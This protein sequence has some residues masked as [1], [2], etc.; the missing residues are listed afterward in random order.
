ME[1]IINFINDK[2]DRN[3]ADKK[4]VLYFKGENGPKIFD[5]ENDDL[6]QILTNLGVNRF[7]EL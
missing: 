7:T 2:L 5:E 6:S 3:I 4:V 1:E